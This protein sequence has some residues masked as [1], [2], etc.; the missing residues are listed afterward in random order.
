M[1]DTAASPER[2]PDWTFDLD[3]PPRPPRTDPRLATAPRTILHAQ[4]QLIA[5]VETMTVLED[6]IRACG[7]AGMT[8]DELADQCSVSIE[9]VHR[10]LAG[11]TLFDFPR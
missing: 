6:Q 7:E 11:G 4:T 3:H 9:A 5:I 8:P 1:S 10:V 2:R